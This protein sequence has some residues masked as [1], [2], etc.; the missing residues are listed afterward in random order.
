MKR[1]STTESVKASALR[2]CHRLTDRPTY[3]TYTVT[4]EHLRTPSSNFGD[5]S[6]ILD[7]NMERAALTERRDRRRCGEVD[8]RHPRA[9]NTSARGE[10]QQR[11]QE[12]HTIA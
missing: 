5:Q 2:V 12:Q 3:L 10:H 9:V 7:G 6:F 8:T 4:L 1:F 11:Y